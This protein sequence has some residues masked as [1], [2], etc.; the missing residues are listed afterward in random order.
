MTLPNMSRSGLHQINPVNHVAANLHLNPSRLNYSDSFCSDSDEV[1]VPR[2]AYI[3]RNIYSRQEQRS[4]WTRVTTTI[5][6]FIMSVVTFLTT[7]MTS[8]YT[9]IR[10]TRKVHQ[11]QR[12]QHYYAYI[13]PQEGILSRIHSQTYAFSR[14]IYR[15][16]LQEMWS[17]SSD[18]STWVSKRDARKSRFPWLFPFLL[19]LSLLTFSVWWLRD[20]SS[21]A[22]TTISENLEPTSSWIW[23]VLTFPVGLMQSVFSS[24]FYGLTVPFS[25]LP[26]FEGFTAVLYDIVM[27]PWHLL[28]S[29]GGVL[30]SFLWNIISLLQLILASILNFK[31][32]LWK[33]P[34]EY[35]A[36]DTGSPTYVSNEVQSDTLKALISAALQEQENTIFSKLSKSEEGIRAEVLSQ[37][38]TSEE[39]LRAELR[40]KEGHG[41]LLNAKITSLQNELRRWKRRFL[42]CC[43]ASD[44]ASSATF[45]EKLYDELKQIF[46]GPKGL[47]LLS[48]IAPHLTNVD[49]TPKNIPQFNETEIRS[50]ISST[51]LDRDDFERKMDNMTKYFNDE[52]ERRSAE[53][54]GAVLEEINAR[55]ANESQMYWDQMSKLRTELSSS[56]LLHSDHLETGTQFSQ[57]SISGWDE[58]RVHMIVQS[59]LA[60]YDADKTGMADYALESQ[61]GQVISTRCT[62]TY[63]VKSPTLSVFGVPLWYPSNSP[64]T[65]IQPGMHPGECWAFVGSQGYLVIQLSHRILVKGFTYEHISPK[66]LPTGKMDS[67]PKEFSIYGLRAEGDHDPILLGNYHYY[68][69]SSSMQYFEV[70]RSGVQPLQ[71]IE[72][73]VKSNH[74]NINYTCMYRFR[75]H[76]SIA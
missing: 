7:T 57:Q 61:G 50:W 71:L 48:A 53:M 73:Q 6:S 28:G 59:A 41:H 62:E 72:M 5:S 10:R 29:I 17:T 26:S 55:I 64:R 37:I 22:L 19:L 30:V 20:D 32:N 18:Q 52:L 33:T 39:K 51:F 3:N 67:A 63:Q 66:L 65:V 15:N 8:V 13:P 34:S 74:G 49:K 38:S 1:D 47:V 23:N 69:N 35:V 4:I 11:V 40:A 14:W 54:K 2:S 9:S 60:L 36:R 75:V 27:A 56:Y 76:G 31:I 24:I 16:I 70:Q 25:L 46:S 68:Q 42:T 12:A 44:S 45:K 21:S 43:T 58:S